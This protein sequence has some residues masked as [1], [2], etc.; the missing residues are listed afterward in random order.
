VVPY[1]RANSIHRWHS[2]SLPDRAAVSSAP[3]SG[4][5]KDDD[6]D[7]KDDC[8]VGVGVAAMVE[9]TGGLLR[10]SAAIVGGLVGSFVS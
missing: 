3:G 6:N 5:D 2:S 7:D 9:I 10:Q 1:S 4:R 8:G